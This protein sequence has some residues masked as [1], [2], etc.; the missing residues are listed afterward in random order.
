MPT[1]TVQRAICQYRVTLTTSKI[2]K[3]FDAT[4]P[5]ICVPAIPFFISMAALIMLLDVLV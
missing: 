1:G 5:G 2:I 3:I 4:V